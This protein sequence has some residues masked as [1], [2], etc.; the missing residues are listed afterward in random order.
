MI[1]GGPWVV[2]LLVVAFLTATLAGVDLEV[3]PQHAHHA[4]HATPVDNHGCGDA[5]CDAPSRAHAHHEP[6]G[7]GCGSLAGHCSGALGVSAAPLIL[8]LPAGSGFARPYGHEKLTGPSVELDTPP[9][10]A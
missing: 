10:K 9:P 8:Q 5:P 7:L 4:A 1:N 2:G 6:A 3:H